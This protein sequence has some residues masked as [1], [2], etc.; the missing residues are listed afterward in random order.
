MYRKEGVT[1]LYPLRTFKK[2]IRE[3]ITMKLTLG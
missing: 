1:V 3:A 2:W